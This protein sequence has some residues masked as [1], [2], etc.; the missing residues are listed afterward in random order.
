MEA[1]VKQHSADEQKKMIMHY[2]QRYEKAERAKDGKIQKWQTL[3]MFDRGEQWFG[4][5][6]PPWVPKPV[7]NWVR[8]VRT[9]KRSNLAS[10][11]PR[12]T[13]YPETEDDVNFVR[14]I[15]KGY[16]FVWDRKRVDRKV[17]RAIDR[18]LLQGTSLGLVVVAALVLHRN[19]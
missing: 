11:I 14:R 1:N 5:N 10:S 15:Q 9:L 7:T 17:R 8:Y 13:F 16:N 3:D 19:Q 4:S 18:A 6:I 12:S 2:T